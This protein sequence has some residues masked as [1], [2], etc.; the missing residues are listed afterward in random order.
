MKLDR[1]AWA[2]SSKDPRIAAGQQSPLEKKILISAFPLAALALSATFLPPPPEGPSP[3]WQRLLLPGVE[4]QAM[5]FLWDMDESGKHHPQQ[6]DTRTENETLHI[7]TH[8][9]VMKNENTWT[10]KGEY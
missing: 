2:T 4:A 9:W 8:R 3:G 6:T 1:L 5:D 10:Q 7:L